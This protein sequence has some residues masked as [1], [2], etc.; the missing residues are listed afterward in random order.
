MP[1]HHAKSP[2]LV[3]ANARHS[4]GYGCALRLGGGLPF[5]TASLKNAIAEPTLLGSARLCNPS[6]VPDSVAAESRIPSIMRGR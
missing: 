4:Q 6:Q 5:T 3:V 1:A 2:L